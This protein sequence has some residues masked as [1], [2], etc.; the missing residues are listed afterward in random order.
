MPLT[1]GYDAS[2]GALLT[3][4]IGSHVNVCEQ[5]TGH[6]HPK[7]GKGLCQASDSMSNHW[8]SSASMDM[9]LPVAAGGH[10]DW[11]CSP[12][13]LSLHVAVAHILE[14]TKDQRPTDHASSNHMLTQ[15]VSA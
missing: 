6:V 4:N 9:C 15:S 1:G 7:E 11:L 14:A 12:F 2:A 10:V 8:H 13:L 3:S 5:M